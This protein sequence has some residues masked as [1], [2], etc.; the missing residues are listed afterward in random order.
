MRLIRKW[1]ESEQL[2]G[3]PPMVYSISIHNGVLH[4]NTR[5]SVLYHIHMLTFG[6]RF[7]LYNAWSFSASLFPC[8][9][10]SFTWESNFLT[11][12][13]RPK[14]PSRIRSNLAYLMDPLNYVLSNDMPILRN[15]V[16]LCA[17]IMFIYSRQFVSWQD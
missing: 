9:R 1:Y 8:M 3:L 7:H 11:S 14:V 5:V 6:Q 17:F 4:I 15:G 13:A 10:T 2:I 16:Q 12:Q